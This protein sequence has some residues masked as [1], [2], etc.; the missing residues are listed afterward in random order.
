MQPPP[1]AQFSPLHMGRSFICYRDVNKAIERH[2][3]I[4]GLRL[5]LKKAIKLE[6]YCL[7]VDQMRDLNFRL[8]YGELDYQCSVD[9]GRPGRP[10]NDERCPRLV[11]LR[12]S[13]DARTL[14]VYDTH[15]HEPQPKSSGQFQSLSPPCPIPEPMTVISPEGLVSISQAHRTTPSTPCLPLPGSSVGL[16]TPEGPHT[17]SS[18][19][20]YEKIT[21]K[22]KKS[23]FSPNEMVVVG[24]A[25]DAQEQF[26]LRNS[27]EKLPSKSNTPS[28]SIVEKTAAKPISK[29][30][31]P[32]SQEDIST[33]KIVRKP[34]V[35]AT[36][37][38][39]DKTTNRSTEKAV[40]KPGDRVSSKPPERV[41][42][43]PQERYTSKTP[44]RIVT[45]STEKIGAKATER[46]GTRQTERSTARV[47]VRLPQRAN[48][49][50][51]QRNHGTV[52]STSGNGGSSQ[53]N[54]LR[55]VNGGNSK[56][57]LR[58]K[59]GGH[60][61]P[62]WDLSSIVPL[63]TELG[64]NEKQ[65]LAHG[66]LL[67]LLRVTSQLPMIEFSH[68]LDTLETLTDA[69]QLEQRVNLTICRDQ[70][71]EC[72]NISTDDPYDIVDLA[73]EDDEHYYEY[74]NGVSSTTNEHRLAFTQVDGPSDKH[75]ESEPEVTDGMKYE[76]SQKRPAPAETFSS[77]NRVYHHSSLGSV[78]GWKMSRS[79][80]YT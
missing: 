4:Y 39:P 59:K 63:D 30:L 45:K 27:P 72:D 44:E 14:V 67:R 57:L 15:V 35:K 12:L 28:P 47:P 21:V 71:K 16:S 73:D 53:T 80:L 52:T 76:L 8:K 69:Y 18:V 10:G 55:S 5:V 49:R 41:A 70:E 34:S 19:C 43:K 2:R 58:R 42:A 78:K 29:Q 3:E 48:E 32:K 36:E 66:V 68:A 11:R 9:N 13:P 54:G 7:T 51:S 17:P 77:E 31:T 33:S 6:N 62:T 60:S 40:S 75:H 22:L 38:P 37:K 25:R 74:E 26:E 50:V 46:M 23:Q 65:Q 1:L 20:G 56:R 24:S 79:S 61:E 64:F